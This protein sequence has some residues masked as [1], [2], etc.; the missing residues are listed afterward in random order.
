MRAVPVLRR[1]ARWDE[2]RVGIEAIAALYDLG[3]DS[4]MLQLIDY[5]KPNAAV[6]PDTFKFTA[7]AGADVLEDT[8]AK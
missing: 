7:P 2:T 6:S 5:L 8:P 3:D 4:M 1:I